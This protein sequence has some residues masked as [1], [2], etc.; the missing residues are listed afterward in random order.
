MAKTLKKRRGAKR[1][2][3]PEFFYKRLTEHFGTDPGALPVVSHVV[4]TYNRPNLH[5]AIQALLSESTSHDLFGVLTLDEYRGIN[6]AHLARGRTS[7]QFLTGPVEYQ[8]VPLAGGEHLACVKRGLYFVR[9]RRG[10]FVLLATDVQ[11]SY[12]PSIR[13]ELMAGDR[14][15]AQ[16]MSRRVA[17][18]TN[19]C[20]AFRG[21][22]ISLELDCNR[23][24]SIRFHSLPSLQPESIIL[25]P[26]VRERLDRQTIGFVRH[27]DAMRRA[28]RHIKRGILLH[29]PPGTGKT[30]S[31]MYIASQLPGRTVLIL[32]GGGIAAI[33]AT[34]LLARSLAPATIILEDV[35]L[36]GTMREHQAVGANALLF[37]LLNQMDGLAEDAD[38]LFMLTTNRPDMIEPAL[39]S[40]PGRID[41]AIEIP[42][43][44]DD[45]RQ[46]LIELYSRGLTLALNDPQQLIEKTRGVSAAF[47]R[48]L[49]RKATL[50]AAE[51]SHEGK[52]SDTRPLTVRDEHL[53][54]AFEE[55]TIAGGK[56]TARLLGNAV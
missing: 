47:I 14:D 42:L 12:P 54:E 5:L 55:L 48:E 16:E 31:A 51:Q 7:S 11:H 30:L 33:E 45:C 22:V 38:I 2:D 6:L 32:T 15:L 40:R 41:Q 3:D 36:I 4:E 50:L 29:G 23:Q 13:V 34:G 20:E 56:I 10:P 44:D 24:M 49:L 19:R 9:S 52:G 53:A 28:G 18:L 46:R 17:Y 43:P 26:A 37:E 27:A 8:D 1:S 39:A 21:Q 35:D 25:P